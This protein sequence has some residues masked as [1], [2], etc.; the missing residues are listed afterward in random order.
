MI[1]DRREEPQFDLWINAL[2]TMLREAPPQ[3]VKL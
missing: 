3:G 2:E 1:E